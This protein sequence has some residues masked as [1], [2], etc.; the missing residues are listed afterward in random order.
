LAGRRLRDKILAKYR[1]DRIRLASLLPEN[2]VTLE[3]LY[4]GVSNVRLKSGEI[5]VFDGVEVERL[6]SEVPQYF[7]RLMRVPLILKY[8]KYRDGSRKYIVVGDVWQRRLCEILV[9]G[10]YSS[11]GMAEIEVEDFIRLLARYKTIIFVTVTL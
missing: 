3:D 8:V 1:S 11:T 10:D 7:W 2:Q 4:K 9:R 6:L 5:H